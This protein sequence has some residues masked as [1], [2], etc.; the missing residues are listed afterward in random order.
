MI[1]IFIYLAKASVLISLFF[2]AYYLLL[3]KETFFIS[4]RSFLLAGILTAFIVP[5]IT[6]TKTVWVTP[7]PLPEMI[8]SGNV[9]VQTNTITENPVFELNWS[10]IAIGL[11]VIGVVFFLGRLFIDILKI[12]KLLTSQKA[13]K[14]GK[15]KFINSDV[16]TSPFSFFNYIVYNAS[17]LQPE[18]LATIIVHEKVHSRQLH[19][20][21]MIISQ[22]ACVFLWFCPFA[23]LYKKQIAQN[24]E[25]I[26][27][28]EAVKSIPDS[29]IYQKTLLKITLQPECIA[30]TNHFYQSLIKKRIIMLNKQQSKKRNFWKFAVVLP[31]LAAFIYLYQVEVIAKEKKQLVERSITVIP[32]NTTLQTND[33]AVGSELSYPLA[34]VF[35][36]DKDMTEATMKQRKQMYK[37][38]FDADVYFENIKRNKNNE[39]FEIKVSVKDKKHI[40][41]YPVYEVISDDDEPIHSFTLNIE[42]ETAV[43]D[44]VIYFTSKNGSGATTT[45]NKPE[46]KES[47]KDL[48][49]Y[50]ENAMKKEKKLV[51]INGVVQ[52]EDNIVFK[53]KKEISIIELSGEEAVKKYGNIAKNGALEFITSD[54]DPESEDRKTIVTSTTTTKINTDINTS[55]TDNVKQMNASP[56]RTVTVTTLRD[57]DGNLI[58]NDGKSLYFVI[59][60]TTT[61][62]QLNNYKEDLEKGGISVSYSDIK[63]NSTGKI[64]AIKISLSDNNAKSKASGSWDVKKSDQAI[65]DIY[66]GKIKG[67]LTVS[68]TK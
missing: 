34:T 25:F 21:D 55:I 57:D 27:D 66:I 15:Y 5:L 49:E 46:P 37:D 17:L 38:L 6:Y 63:R 19:S 47:K 29:K 59:N 58:A 4:I 67:K 42:K 64:I 18:E 32:E 52:T 12:Y 23:W 20:L 41:A 13:V 54:F 2:I 14:E 45:F 39:I 51:V 7:Q 8:S 56:Y 48:N 1:S 65:P 62:I 68:A 36:V 16:V 28:A 53:D 22:L 43:A 44:N 24:L 33:I 10:D 50:V 30:I 35:V 9:I 40:K 60:S 11:Y 3:K 61:D 26:A 31:A